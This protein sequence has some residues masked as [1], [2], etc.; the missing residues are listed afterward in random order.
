MAKSKGSGFKPG[1]PSTLANGG[2]IEGV[3]LHKAI[4]MGGHPE[5]GRGK[6]VAQQNSK[7]GFQKKK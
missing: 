6:G 5:V 2:R 7:G 3:N 1:R 4:A